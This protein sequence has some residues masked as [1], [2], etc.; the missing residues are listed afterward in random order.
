MSFSK[1]LVELKGD[2][3]HKAYAQKLGVSEALLRKY[4]NGSDPSL[5]KAA[6]IADKTG[7]S[8]NWLA[9][10][11]D[12]PSPINKA[13]DLSCLEDAMVTVEQVSRRNGF[14]LTSSQVAKLTITSYEYMKS[15]NKEP[16]AIVDQEALENFI[17][18]LSRMY[19]I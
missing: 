10:G 13:I 19:I 18:H 14:K 5:S 1:R 6:Q 15:I 16:T 17:V 8:L 3:T 11:N 2:L 12:S 9:L 4:M 7:K